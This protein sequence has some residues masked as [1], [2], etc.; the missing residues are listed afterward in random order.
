MCVCFF[1]SGGIFFEKKSRQQERWGSQHLEKNP[2]IGIKERV[3]PRI[4]IP[5]SLDVSWGTY[6]GMAKIPRD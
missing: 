6:Q 4:L 2:C 3:H 1:F 5:N